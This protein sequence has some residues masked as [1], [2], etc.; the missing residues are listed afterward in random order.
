MPGSF[1]SI[2]R[3]RLLPLVG[4]FLLASGPIGHATAAPGPGDGQ[5]V[6][7]RLGIALVGIALGPQGNRFYSLPCPVRGVIH[8]VDA[9]P[10]LHTRFAGCD[11]G[12]GVVVDGEGRLWWPDPGPQAGGEDR[13]C[14]FM[15]GPGLPVCPSDLRWSGTLEV[16]VD[17]SPA[18]PLT[19]IRIH[20]LAIVDRGAPF[21]EDLDFRGRVMGFGSMSVTLRDSTYSVTDGRLPD[22]VFSPG[23]LTLSTIPNPD[24]AVDALTDAD[25][26]RLA[27]DG[28]DLLAR[29]LFDE[30]LETQRGPHSHDLDCGTV[31]IEVK[32]NLPIFHA[33]W[34]SCE[35]RGLVWSGSFRLS[36]N[37]FAERVYD[38]SLEGDVEV[39]G[40][41]ART[42]IHRVR[43]R[44]EHDPPR[45]RHLSG[46]IEGEGGR[47]PFEYEL[48]RDE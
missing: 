27:F 3:I 31:E 44:S 26:A 19:E 16:H 18:P 34:Q 38:F 43:W 13:F 23:G 1:L 45:S 15:V 37:E 6:A 39:G 4:A 29:W 48:G 32:E 47:R 25:L 20:E 7:S 9:E 33:D 24:G 40:A 46:L 30:T 41:L 28:F 12:E 35:F 21:P 11:L 17:G 14:G 8:Y 42:A 10:G 36:W 5:R 22:E 2:P